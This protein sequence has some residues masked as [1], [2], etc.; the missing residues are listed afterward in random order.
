MVEMVMAWRV[1]NFS[2]GPYIV[3]YAAT[4][5]AI[6]S[7]NIPF[8]NDAPNPSSRAVDANKTIQWMKLV[9]NG[10]SLSSEAGLFVRG[11]PTPLY[12]V[13]EPVN[14]AKVTNLGLGL[15]KRWRGAERPRFCDY[16]S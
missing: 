2:C 1:R 16:S 7:E 13:R 10:I 12:N 9:L 15:E 8:I 5:K 4:I 14:Y 6:E 3:S 11:Y